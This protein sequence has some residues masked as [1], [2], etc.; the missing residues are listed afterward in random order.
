MLV[1]SPPGSKPFTLHSRLFPPAAKNPDSAKSQAGPK[2]A[3]KS[4]TAALHSAN[5]QARKPVRVLIADDHLFL[6]RGVRQYLESQPWIEVCGE[7]TD[8]RE[9]VEKAA[10]LLPDVAIVDISLPEMSGLEVTRAIR[11]KHPAIEVLVLTMHF[12][13]QWARQ[14]MKAG[15]RAYVLKTDP[16]EHLLT[17]ISHLRDHKPF[18]TPRVAD[19]VLTGF[20]EGDVAATIKRA[21]AVEFP[22]GPLSR[23][24]RQVI[25][26]LAEGMS[27]KQAASRLG[28]SPRTIESHRMHV[29]HKLRL[30]SFSEM[31]RYAVRNNMVEA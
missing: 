8:G 23:R 30:G 4:S 29:M 3:Q 11:L 15:A 25:Q 10:E 20:V 19:V 2:P 6:L 31:I 28:V 12:S 13:E 22:Y 7:A 21:I 5:N 9:A 1:P 17:A 26:L 27:N 16:D 14:A 24:E 18:L